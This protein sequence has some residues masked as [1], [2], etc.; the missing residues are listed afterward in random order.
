MD[1]RHLPYPPFPPLPAE[2]LQSLCK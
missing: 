2:K 1:T